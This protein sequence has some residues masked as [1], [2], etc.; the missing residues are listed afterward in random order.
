MT[1][2]EYLEKQ[3]AL[4]EAKW[5]A[6]DDKDYKRADKLQAEIE[7]LTDPEPDE[8]LG[9]AGLL[10]FDDNTTSQNDKKW[11]YNLITEGHGKDW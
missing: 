8:L 6:Y 11:Y 5:E 7:A 4:V 2:Q 10:E 9:D 1:K 3:Q